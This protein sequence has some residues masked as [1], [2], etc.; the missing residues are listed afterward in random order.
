MKNPFS[1]LLYITKINQMRNCFVLYFYLCFILKKKQVILAFSFI[2]FPNFAIFVLYSIFQK[3]KS[4]T[5]HKY[6]CI[7]EDLQNR[8]IIAVVLL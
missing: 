7:A 4:I 3:K 1:I 2:Y 6:C 8:K 5:H